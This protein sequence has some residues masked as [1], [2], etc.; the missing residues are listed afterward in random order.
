MA[1]FSNIFVFLLSL[2]PKKL[3]SDIHTFFLLSNI[4][5]QMIIL[6]ISMVG[7]QAAHRQLRAASIFVVFFNDLRFL[8]LRKIDFCLFCFF[9]SMQQVQDQNSSYV[10]IIIVVINNDQ[11]INDVMKAPTIS[12]ESWHRFSDLR[13][14][15]WFGFFVGD[16]AIFCDLSL[17]LSIVCDF[18]MYNGVS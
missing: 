14:W 7:F 3:R 17:L 12:A 1:T 13:F 9:A 2:F 6:F 5:R 10:I 15:L 16:F 11:S 18:Q 4:K 8:K